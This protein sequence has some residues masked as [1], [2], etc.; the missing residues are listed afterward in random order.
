MGESL[1]KNIG[2]VFAP[3]PKHGGDEDEVAAHHLTAAANPRANAQPARVHNDVLKFEKE[4]EEPEAER[5]L[6]R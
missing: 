3:Y 6:Q 1:P 2:D 5:H 4:V